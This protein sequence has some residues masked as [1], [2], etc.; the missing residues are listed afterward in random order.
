[1]V[2]E[3]KADDGTVFKKIVIKYPYFFG[4][5]Q[6]EIQANSFY[7]SI[8][9]YYQQQAQQVQ[10]DYKKFIKRGGETHSLPMELHYDAKVSYADE[11][12]LC[13]INE[14]SESVLLYNPI[15]EV[16]GEQQPTAQNTITLPKKTLECYTFDIETGLYVTK[17]S[18]IGKDYQKISDV[19]YRIHGGYSCDDIFDENAVATD[20]PK[21]T[22]N[23][24]EKIYNS[25]SALCEDGYVFCY[26][27][28]QG[29]R[30]DVVIPFDIIDKLTTTAEE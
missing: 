10:S 3:G 16:T 9:S 19:L 4:E 12:K 25:A 27:T 17:D 26:V 22:D 6:G 5:S 2:I 20:I 18:I 7:Q 14:I 24:G 29:I 15:E 11:E 30:E 13:L 23:I 1:M 21:D 28:D 8:I